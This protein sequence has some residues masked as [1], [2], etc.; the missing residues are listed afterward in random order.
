MRSVNTWMLS[1]IV[2]T[3]TTL[4]G[5]G[6]ERLLPPG[7]ERPIAVKMRTESV[8]AAIAQLDAVF[9]AERADARERIDSVREAGRHGNPAAVPSLLRAYRQKKSDYIPEYIIKTLDA[10]GGEAAET[11]I[12]QIVAEARERG[13]SDVRHTHYDVEYSKI[14]WTAIPLLSKMGKRGQDELQ[15]IYGNPRLGWGPRVYAQK[16]ILLADLEARGIEGVEQKVQALVPLFRADK[17]WGSGPDSIDNTALLWA[18]R[19]MGP[20]AIP[21]LRQEA[22]R[23]IKSEDKEL[24]LKEELTTLE[25]YNSSVPCKQIALEV[26]M[27]ADSMESYENDRPIRERRDRELAERLAKDDAFYPSPAPE[28]NSVMNVQE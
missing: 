24:A 17:D 19:D 20:E 2:L 23:L 10:I 26:R 9:S 25:I 18:L 15:T 22:E 7:Y 3:S 8:E 4:C 5:V 1:T 13:P 14:M 11:A 21:F 27:L 28:S 12:L 16:Y 6:R